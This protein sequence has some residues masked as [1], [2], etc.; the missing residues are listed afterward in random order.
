EANGRLIRKVEQSAIQGDPSIKVVFFKLSLTTGWDCPR[1]E[2]MMSFRRAKDHTH[3]AQLVGRM[4]RTPLPR[5]I[6]PEE[7]LTSVELFLPHYDEDTVGAI[8]QALQN[9]EAATGV[10]T[11]AEEKKNVQ[12]LHRAPG[13]DQEFAFV[14]ALPSYAVHRYPELPPIKRLLR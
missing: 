10:G 4:I 12:V 5:R 9:P 11:S 3:I 2:V 7:V 14:E 8:L 13:L 6:E 1:A